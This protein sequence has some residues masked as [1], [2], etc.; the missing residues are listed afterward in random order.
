MRTKTSR[1]ILA[2]HQTQPPMDPR[3]AVRRVRVALAGVITKT[4]EPSHFWYDITRE[5]P[6]AAM[7]FEKERDML[8][9]AIRQGCTTPKRIMLYRITQLQDDLSQFAEAPL[10]AELVMQHLITEQAESM[11]AI[12]LAHAMPTA[13]HREEAIR[14][15]EEA[16]FLG[17]VACEVLRSGGSLLPAS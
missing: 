13:A 7:P 3:M 1:V 15:T 5:E 16:S 14:E 10:L 11:A 9:A 6:R 8:H 4:P 2:N 12:S 17:R